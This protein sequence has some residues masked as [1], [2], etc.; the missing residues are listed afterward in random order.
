LALTGGIILDR[1]TT[2]PLA[3]GLVLAVA[4]LIA[5]AIN[6]RGGPT[7]LAKVYLGLALVGFG[8]AYAQVRQEPWRTDNIR[9]FADER[10]QLV[11]LRGVLDEEPTVSWPEPPDPLRTMP[12]AETTQAVLRVTHLRKQDDWL[13]V[14]GRVRLTVEGR[15]RGLHVGDGVNVVGW[16][17]LPQPSANPGEFDYASYLRDQDIQAVVTVEK[18]PD[19][20]VLEGEGNRVSWV[21]W[22]AVVRGWSQRVLNEHL[23][24]PE[25][26]LAIALLLGNTSLITDAEREKYQ[27]AGTAPA[28]GTSMQYLVGMYLRTGVIH[29]LAISGQHLVVLAGALW[30]LARAPRVN[31]RSAA[32]LVAL[33]LFAYALLTGGRPPVMRAATTAVVICAA[34]VVRRPVNPANTFALAWL[35]V[36]LL[37]PA[38][39]FT[40]GCQLSFLAVAVLYW[41][42]GQWLRRE[43]DP[44]ERLIDESR[45]TGEKLARAVGQWLLFAYGSVALIWVT[46]APLVAARTHLVSPVGILLRVNAPYFLVPHR[47]LS[48]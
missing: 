48:R 12:D 13:P 47:T 23:P 10:D 24:E 27:R 3:L 8:A 15:T 28:T 40:A 18:T 6:R 35:V 31:R 46:S 43:V 7:G 22:R 30:W 44:L 32:V 4:G 19:G 25:S 9:H 34:I 17:A 14:S 45:S 41:V 11:R 42:S 38:D 2:I 33:L 1:F 39:L 26:G 36:A 5:W 20:I 16:L 37:N 21:R 29:V